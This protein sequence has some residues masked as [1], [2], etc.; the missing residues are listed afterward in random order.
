MPDFTAEELRSL[1]SYDP[2]TGAFTRLKSSRVDRIGQ[3]AGARDT[4]GHVQIRV[5]GRLHL[6]HRLAWMWVHGQWPELQID[7]I[8][9]NRSD[10]RVANLRLATSRQNAQNRRRAQADNKTSGLLGVSFDKRVGKY[11]GQIADGG[12][13]KFLGYHETAAQAHEAYLRAKAVLHEFGEV[14][15]LFRRSE[16]RDA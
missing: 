6:A 8:N 5:L 4:K 11:F 10:N 14:A 9:G 12:K 7:H 3:S 1:L 15:S 2:E 13:K 16:M